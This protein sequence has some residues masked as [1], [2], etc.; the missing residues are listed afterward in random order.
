VQVAAGG[1]AAASPL[2]LVAAAQHI[3]PL[4]LGRRGKPA[5]MSKLSLSKSCRSNR[6]IAG[7][8]LDAWG[9]LVRLTS[10]HPA[11]SGLTEYVGIS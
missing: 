10:S 4:L 9:T 3:R 11:S 7:A 8:P 5:T 1:A 2:R 6:P